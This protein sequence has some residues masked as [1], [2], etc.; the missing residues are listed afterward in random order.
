MASNPHPNAHLELY[1]PFLQSFSKRLPGAAQFKAMFPERLAF[2]EKPFTTL[3]ELMILAGW[4]I[5]FAS[6]YLNFDPQV[7][8]SGADY[9]LTVNF[10]HVWTRFR[11]CGLCFFWNGGLN[12]GSPAFADLFP[13]SWHPLVMI[14]TLGWGVVNGSKIALC[15][16]FFMA[17]LAQWWLA[18]VLGL[19]WLAR[20]WSAMLAVVA[21]NVAGRMQMGWFGVALA[22]A[23]AAM[24][25]PPLIRVALTGSRRSAV[26]LGILLASAAVAGQGYLQFGLGLLLPLTLILLPWGKPNFRLVVKRY[27]QACVLAFLFAA[28]FLL[29]FALNFSQ[30][31]KVADVNFGGIQSFTFIPLS[32]VANDPRFYGT[33]I[34][35][36]VEF[37]ALY[38][39]YIGWMAVLLALVGVRLAR[40]GN[41]ARVMFFLLLVAMGAVVAASLEPRQFLDNLFPKSWL[42]YQLM[43]LRSSPVIAGLAVLPVLGIAAI[44]VDRLY[45]KLAVELQIGLKS[46]SGVRPWVFTLN[47]LLVIPL[48]WGIWNVKQVTQGWV[49]TDSLSPNVA[50]VIAALRTPTLEWVNFPWGEPAYLETAMAKGLKIAGYPLAWGWKDRPVPDALLQAENKWMPK[51]TELVGSIPDVRGVKLYRATSD[52]EYAEVEHDSGESSICAAHGDAGD[53]DVHCETTQPGILVV[54]ENNWSGWNAA[55]DGYSAGIGFDRWIR[56]ALPAG[57]HNIQLRYRPWEGILGIVLLGLGCVWSV[58]LWRKP[59]NSSVGDIESQPQDE[60][61]S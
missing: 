57:K 59:D 43:S 46:V 42:G 53:I 15:G 18:R 26:L 47:W 25:F 39:N 8:P 14:T 30:I 35:N 61:N 31:T 40:A 24:V 44:G 29:T 56:I 9:F 50:R 12:G 21:G 36:M 49:R 60:I 16:I 51:D 6:P 7:Q 33:P 20:M 1:E 23:S 4:A 38:V 34:L 45:A 41:E 48:L 13:S 52:Q 22:T 10:H 55:V 11:E 19:G 32:F 54:K 2:P 17:G 37:P 28:P 3:V 5:W 58:Y 27:F